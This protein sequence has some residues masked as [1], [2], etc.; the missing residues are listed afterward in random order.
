MVHRHPSAHLERWQGL[1]IPHSAKRPGAPLRITALPKEG[2]AE[3][4]TES[5]VI[6][7]T[8]NTA[9]TWKAAVQESVGRFLGL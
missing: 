8:N 6:Y 9:Y 2:E 1:R 3:M 7:A 5:G 4:V